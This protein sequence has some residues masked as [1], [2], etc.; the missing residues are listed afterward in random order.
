MRFAPQRL[1]SCLTHAET[2]R[3]RRKAQR[4]CTSPTQSHSDPT[5]TGEAPG[6]AGLP[7]TELHPESQGASLGGQGLRKTWTVLSVLR[8]APYVSSLNIINELFRVLLCFW[9]GP[10]QGPFYIFFTLTGNILSILSYW[11]MTRELVFMLTLRKPS[12]LMVTVNW[13]D[14]FPHPSAPPRP[15]HLTLVEFSKSFGVPK[16]LGKC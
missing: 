3:N 8:L 2:P 9:I 15:E 16:W 13:L 12:L 11:N 14:L 4:A 1:G 7:P 6:D 10:G 5:I